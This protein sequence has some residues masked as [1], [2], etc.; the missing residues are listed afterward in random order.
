MPQTLC[1]HGCEK[2][3]RALRINFEHL[4]VTVVHNIEIS[5]AIEG[6]A[7]W[8]VEKIA[9]CE[10]RNDAIFGNLCDR[11]ATAICDIDIARFL[12]DRDAYRPAQTAG[13]EWFRL[14]FPID[15]GDGIAV[16]IRL[17]KVAFIVDR[18]AGRTVKARRKFVTLTVRRNLPDR[19]A[20]VGDVDIANRVDCYTSDAVTLNNFSK[21]MDFSLRARRNSRKEQRQHEE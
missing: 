12:F 7:V 21:R 10:G 6:N 9:L 18:V 17:Q 11:I 5:L 20:E 16:E 3:D 1:G 15:L 14:T 19:L 13:D 4:V 8:A 2:R